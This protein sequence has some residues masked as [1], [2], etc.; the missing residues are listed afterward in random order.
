M[1][2]RTAI[3]IYNPSDP[4]ER[5]VQDSYHKVHGEW[6]GSYPCQTIA[7][8]I[9]KLK[10]LDDW[11]DNPDLLEHRIS[12]FFAPHMSYKKDSM[13]FLT[14]L[15]FLRDI[16]EN[17]EINAYLHGPITFVARPLAHYLFRE[18]PIHIHVKV[19]TLKG[20]NDVDWLDLD[21]LLISESDVLLE[22]RAISQIIAT[23]QQD[24]VQK[25]LS[26]VNEL[27]QESLTKAALSMVSPGVFKSDRHERDI[28]AD[29][30]VWDKGEREKALVKIV[31][32]GE[33]GLIWLEYNNGLT[34]S[35]PKISF[36]ERYVSV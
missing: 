31:E 2:K 12:Y 21:G 11:L 3:A 20:Y 34:V 19:S 7:C 5:A 27:P 9:Q 36:D 17:S 13:V 25:M 33:T 6:L 4:L 15:L 23:Q 18:Y 26:E 28:A 1:H 35:I 29:D 14:H 24:Q 22:R 16:L 30:V 10:S 8:A 32:P